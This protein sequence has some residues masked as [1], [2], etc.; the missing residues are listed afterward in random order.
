VSA[1]TLL[2][3]TGQHILDL[4]FPPRCVLCHEPGSQLCAACAAGFPR[5]A[6]PVCQICGRPTST[7]GI[8]TS[9][10]QNPP[11]IDGIRSA[12][13]HEGGARKAIHFFKY[14]NRPTLAGPLAEILAEAWYRAPL[15][16]DIVTAVP[17]HVARERERGYNQANLLAKAFARLVDKPVSLD[18]LIR[19]RHTKT[20]VG[21]SAVDRQE[22]V[23]DAFV[24]RASSNEVTTPTHSGDSA[25]HPSSSVQGKQVLII[26]DVCTTGAT[27]EACSQALKQ[28]GAAAV[29]GFTLARPAHPDES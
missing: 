19:V 8:C 26:D 27:L 21:L 14:N 13:L 6:P 12:L 22:N 20:Q 4:L 29:W 9:C 25:A 7:A 2:H 3:L 28:V 10:N 1:N 24:Y 15:P 16:A 5:I 23:R 17:L 18:M 11:P